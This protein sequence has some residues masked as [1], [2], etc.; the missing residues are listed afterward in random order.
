MSATKWK[1]WIPLSRALAHDPHLTCVESLDIVP[2]QFR[3]I[4]AEVQMQNDKSE[5]RSFFITQIENGLA[6]IDGNHP[7]AG[8]QLRTVVTIEGGARARPGEEQMSGIHAEQMKSP[9]S[10]N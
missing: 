5:T 1:Y 4:G 7:R 8:K 10:I 9:T 2:L 3:R 6:T